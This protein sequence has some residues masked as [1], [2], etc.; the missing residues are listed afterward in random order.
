MTQVAMFIISPEQVCEPNLYFDIL[1]H[2]CYTPQ[3]MF[4]ERT[5]LPHFSIRKYADGYHR[6]VYRRVSGTM[7]KVVDKTDL[8]VTE[9]LIPAV[10][11]VVSNTELLPVTVR[12]A[13]YAI[14]YGLLLL[15]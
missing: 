6:N 7:G 12:T 8:P 14:E 10:T 13:A 5:N 11:V 2:I 1:P 3:H 15:S 4:S 9:V